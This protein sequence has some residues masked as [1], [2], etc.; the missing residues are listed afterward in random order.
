MMHAVQDNAH[1]FPSSNE[2]AEQQLLCDAG[3]FAPTSH[4]ALPERV[5]MSPLEVLA[6]RCWR[7][8][9]TYGRSHVA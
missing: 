3:G 2:M 1:S 5:L 4:I 7:W 9:R 6:S 8:G